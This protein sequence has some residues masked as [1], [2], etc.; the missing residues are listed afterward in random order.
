MI[1]KNLNFEIYRGDKVTFIG[2]NGAGKSTII[3]RIIGELS[4]KK[5]KIS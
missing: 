4:P 1:I 2:K 3:K 5:G